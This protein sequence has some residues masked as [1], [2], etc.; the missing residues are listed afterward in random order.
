[1]LWI[2][3]DGWYHNER[4]DYDKRRDSDISKS[5]I[6]V[7]RFTN[8]EIDKNLE[9]VVYFL[10]NIVKEREKYFASK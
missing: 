2:E 7:V 3:I 5:W 1:M 9:W 6:K 4:Q 10:D 8:D